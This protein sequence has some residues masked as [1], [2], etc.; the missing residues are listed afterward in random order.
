M[1]GINWVDRDVIL[2][3]DERGGRLDGT[4]QNPERARGSYGN[5][6]C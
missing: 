4:V 3:G 6:L 5:Y 2:R 1:D